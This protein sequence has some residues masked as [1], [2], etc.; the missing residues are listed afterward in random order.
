MRQTCHALEN[1]G[2]FVVTKVRIS[3]RPALHDVVQVAESH[4]LARYVGRLATIREVVSDVRDVGIKVVILPFFFRAVS[5]RSGQNCPG[6]ERKNV[7]LYRVFV[8]DDDG[9][10]TF[11]YHYFYVIYLSSRGRTRAEGRS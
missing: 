7:L 2:E 11:F 4:T 6:A 10:Y 3:P 8:V 5:T 9:A 1:A